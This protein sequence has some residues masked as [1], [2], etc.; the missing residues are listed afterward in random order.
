M[1]FPVVCF[2]AGVGIGVI[3]MCLLQIGRTPTVTDEAER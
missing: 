3:I 1:M 2:L